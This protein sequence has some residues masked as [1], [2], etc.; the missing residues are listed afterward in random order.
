V[1]SAVLGRLS[2]DCRAGRNCRVLVAS[3]QIIAV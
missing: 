3:Y 2:A 1:P